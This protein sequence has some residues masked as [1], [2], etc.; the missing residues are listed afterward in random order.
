MAD[1]ISPKD[2]VKKFVY[3]FQSTDKSN[4]SAPKTVEVTDPKTYFDALAT[5]Q[6]GF[7]PIGAN[8]LWHGGIHFGA[9]TGNTLSQ[10]K[11]VRC[12]ADGE[13][14][15]YRID[16]KYPEVEYP[17]AGKARYSRGFVLVKHRLELPKA[18]KT[19]GNNTAQPQSNGG[20]TPTPTPAGTATPAVTPT[21]NPNAVTPTPVPASAATNT[22]PTTGGASAPATA[23]A[24]TEPSLVFYSLYMHLL[25]WAG[26]EADKKLTRP[27]FWGGD[28]QYVVSDKSDDK[29]E[30]LAPGQLG[31]RVRDAANKPI[32]ILPSGTKFTLGAENTA[33]KGYFAIASI[34]SGDSVPAGQYAGGYVFKKELE[35]ISVPKAKDAV[36]VLDKP[37]PIKAGALIGYMG[38]YQRYID[39]NPMANAATGRPLLQVEI[40]SG[41]DVPGF[42][43]KS[44][45]RAAQLDAKQKTL[46]KVDVGA[47]LALPA[48]A[49][50]SVAAG[51]DVKITSDSPKTG[52]WV[53]VQKL[54]STPAPTKKEPKKVSIAPS[55]TAFW[56]ERTMLG[57]NGQRSS[58][59][60]TMSAWSQF[61]LQA[62]N[63]SGPKA[64]YLRV[65]PTKL[66]KK[67]AT[68]A[69][70]TRW[71]EV[72]VGTEDGSSKTGWAREKGQASVA[73]CSPWDWP[74]FEVLEIDAT[75]PVGF[76][77]NHIVR[78]GHAQGDEK[79]KL[80]G[81]GA[82]AD[83][84]VLF[85]KLFDIIDTDDD[86]KVVPDELRAALR[87]PWLAQ[88]ISRLITRYESEWY[89]SGMSKWNE[90]DSLIPEKD[91]PDWEAEKKRIEKLLWWDEVKG[92]QGFPTNPNAYHFHP[93]GFIANCSSVGRHPVVLNNGVQRELEFLE[94]YDGSTIDESDYQS[95]ANE[96]GCEVAA[97][98]AV[99][100]AETGATGSYYSFA[101]W[102]TVPAI[103]YERHYFHRLTNGAHD[104]AE[105]EISDAAR[106]GYGKYSAQYRKLLTAYDL[107]PDAALK[108]AS[109]GK[110]QIMGANHAAAGY[111]SVQDFVS[112]ISASEKNHLKAF[113]SFIKS[114][115]RLSTAIV[116]KDW[117]SFARAY[118]G[119]A[120][121]G[122]DTKMRDNYNALK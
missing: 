48:T 118:N 79:A 21:P 120:Q 13:V 26:F 76:Y 92:K 108:S 84:S 15:A 30:A 57:Q 40:F 98:K 37:E 60:T 29:E 55:G 6:D 111:S 9:E 56:V 52:D 20:V 14:I 109:W 90:I 59:A 38:Q 5:A 95:A 114:D 64:A 73:L 97:I 7:Y 116:S 70:G 1:P 71:W 61:P 107:A 43:A 34:V 102:D 86:K 117:L 62:S 80:E 63:T 24:S 32:A 110:F 25:D 77:A 78:Q 66:L 19:T 41:D 44:K 119:P 46:L 53:K 83:N 28:K 23:S 121:E 51:E 17:N 88:A 113:V 45:A 89:A 94:F 96:L 122:Y 68:E 103:L 58:T 4:A 50:Q 101:G 8:A 11:G 31:L 27:G 49:D 85:R 18:P 2:A 99:S 104:K 75:T 54:V 12:I 91:K 74:G 112:D 67:S 81:Q 36:V 47:T 106:G 39:T 82:P 33:K 42:I 100:M 72:D 10:D 3:P 87:Q 69:D 115:S 16:D 65:A 93:I 105:P 35:A 22:A